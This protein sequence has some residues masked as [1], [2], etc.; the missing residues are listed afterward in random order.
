MKSE[1][2][3]LRQRIEQEITAMRLLM[4]G[5]AIVSRHDIIAQRHRHLT[6]HRKALTNLVG[7]EQAGFMFFAIYAQT[8]EGQVDA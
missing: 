2:A 5:P 6:T 7:E 3:Q 4:N 1:L 8:M